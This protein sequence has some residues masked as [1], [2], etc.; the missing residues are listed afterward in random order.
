MHT[1]EFHQQSTVL[2]LHAIKKDSSIRESGA[3]SL[4]DALKSNTTLTTLNLRS[5]YKTNSTLMVSINNPLFHSHENNSQQDW[6]QGNNII[7]WCI[8]IKLNTHKA[9]SGK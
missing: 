5:K 4:S 7:E 8:E 6:I 3:T 9:Q 1:N 2:I